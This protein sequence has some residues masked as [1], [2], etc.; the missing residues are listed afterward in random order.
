MSSSQTARESEKA[1]T[2]GRKQTTR[3]QQNEPV[4]TG[5][6]LGQAVQRAQIDPSRLTPTDVMALQRTI[7]NQAVVRLLG[8]SSPP[9]QSRRSPLVI[10]PKLKVGPVGDKYEQ[11][12]DRVAQQVTSQ[13]SKPVSQ[14]VGQIQS[15]QREGVGEDDED[16]QMK[17]LVQRA[18]TVGPADDQYERE[19]DQISG[20]LQLSRI[21]RATP[22]GPE[23]GALNGDLE[24][25][26][27]QTQGSGSSMPQ[28]VRNSLEPKLGA[29]LGSVKV[30]TDSQSVQLNKDL[31]AKAF[32]H[33][34]HIYY[35]AGQSPSD[36]KLTAHEAVHTIQQ[37]A[38]QQTRRK[39]QDESATE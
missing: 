21:Q 12:A 39:P 3:H 36:T 9:P 7:G 26:I 35:G 38:V 10:Q 30:H 5:L 4:A 24:S 32:T 2:S 27:R 13:F 37:G 20:N 6:E 34:N 19:A 1:K 17:P 25:R 22:V 29:D 28:G 18:L 33:K 11:E 16:L 8:R 15:V 14:T 23:G 31:G